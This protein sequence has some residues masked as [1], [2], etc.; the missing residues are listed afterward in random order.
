MEH[1][2]FMQLY[3]RALDLRAKLIDPQTTQ[4]RAFAREL[5]GSC[6]FYDVR[7]DL[8][9]KH[10]ELGVLFALSYAALLKEDTGQDSGHTINLGYDC[11]EGHYNIMSIFAETLVRIGV[12]D[13]GG[14]IINWGV[15]GGGEIKNWGMFQRA[16]T[17]EDGHWAYGTKS[18]RAEKKLGFKFGMLGGVFCK[19]NIAVRLWEALYTREL[20]QF[21]IV[22][23]P[24]QNIVNVGSLDQHNTNVAADMIRARTGATG[25]QEKLLEGVTVGIDACGSPL[26]IDTVS[27]LRKLGATVNAKNET[28]DPSFDESRIQDPNERKSQVI[29][30][31]M[32][33]VEETGISQIILDP[34]A[35]RMTFVAVDSQ[36]KAVCLTGS[37]ILLLVME[38]LATH[39]P[40]GH[41]ITVIG[42][43]R[44]RMNVE[45]LEQALNGRGH[46][47]KAVISEAGY[48]YIHE[49]V[50]EANAAI[51]V[52]QT[53]HVMVPALTH[54]AWGAPTEY[55][56]NQGGDHG[57]ILA[58][59]LL[60]MMKHKWDMRS[61]AQ[62]LDHI[63]EEYNLPPDNPN[64]TK[65]QIDKVNALAKY[66]IAEAM[67]QMAQNELNAGKFSFINFDSG[68][69][70]KNK[71]TG[72]A[73]LVRH[74]NS[75][76]GFT[77]SVEGVTEADANFMLA[78]GAALM[79][80]AVR[81]VR[82][83]FIAEDNDMKD[84]EIDM[85]HLAEHSGRLTIAEANTTNDLG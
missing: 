76:P 64:E 10:P 79:E 37:N 55:K 24:L 73:V 75:G 71:E 62:Q 17:G 34:D 4:D 28:L 27:M 81:R 6:S 25:R 65:P 56:G 78:L 39:N 77:V 50:G 72:A 15:M 63:K 18:H 53:C 82:E 40:E 69:S 12:T 1:G 84:F 54:L 46:K 32:K 85:E 48:P 58:A 2:E 61:L 74:S 38:N 45:D 11:Y 9:I 14:G 83:R 13:N 20:P 21:G 80:E 36:G 8:L 41:D 31:I 44:A 7:T 68:L 33:E 35:D 19:E 3:N 60:G 23:D 52:E 29:K 49:K 51:G 67:R 16:V 47:I 42:D 57:A 30:A 26:G 22:A 70:I 59:C 43:S 5:Q 66:D